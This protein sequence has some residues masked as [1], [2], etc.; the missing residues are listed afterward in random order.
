MGKKHRLLTPPERLE[1]MQRFAPAAY[2][3]PPAF[4]NALQLEVPPDLEPWYFTATAES[5]QLFHSR[6]LREQFAFRVLVPFAEMD[7][8]D[9]VFC[10]DGAD[11]SGDPAVLVIHT[12]CDPGW[13]YRGHWP[14]YAA[15]F[16]R[17]EQLHELFAADDDRYLEWDV[18]LF[19][20][21]WKAAPPR[22]RRWWRWPRAR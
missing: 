17:A 10:F 5:R 13:E 14:S 12:F 3:F 16:E 15:W 20:E 11:V 21:A 1:E 4:L 22:R 18:P 6:V 19:D 9:D 8:T 2:A 7:G